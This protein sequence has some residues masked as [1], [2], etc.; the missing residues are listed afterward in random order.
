MEGIVT[1]R[2][3][4]NYIETGENSMENKS[5]LGAIKNAVQREVEMI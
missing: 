2:S 4:K 1:I 5:N 3:D